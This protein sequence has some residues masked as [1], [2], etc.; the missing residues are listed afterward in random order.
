MINAINDWLHSKNKQGYIIFDGLADSEDYSNCRAY[1][2]GDA[3]QGIV[4]YI[5]GEQ[6]PPSLILVTSDKALIYV[7]HQK[8]VRVESPEHFLNRLSPTVSL[9]DDDK[10]EVDDDLSDYN[11]F[12]KE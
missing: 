4:E 1:Y 9:T 6:N 8:R 11:N 3:D 7:A 10:P 2:A 5:E 12:K